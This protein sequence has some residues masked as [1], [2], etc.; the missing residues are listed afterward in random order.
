LNARVGAACFALICATG[1]AGQEPATVAVPRSLVVGEAISAAQRA[2]EIVGYTF[3][4]RAGSKYLIELAQRGLDFTVTVEGG[5]GARSYNSPLKRDETELVIVEA[6]QD[7]RFLVTVAAHELTDASGEHEIRLLL[8]DERIVPDQ[9]WVAAWRLMTDAAAANAAGERTGAEQARNWYSVAAAFWEQL[10]QTRRQAQALY[11][12]GMV[13]Y[14]GLENWGGAF[15]SAD[16]A[17]RLYRG[18]D[19]RLYANTLVLRAYAQIETASE[20]EAATQESVFQRALTTFDEA[21]RI[22]D[23]LGN[24]FDKAHVLNFIGITHW[25]R[26]NRALDDYA[27][28]RK[29]YNESADLFS[30]LGEWREEINCLQ[31]IVVLDNA[32]GR[33]LQAIASFERILDRLPPGRDPK[34][35]ATILANLGVAHLAFGNVDEALRLQSEAH[36]LSQAVHD[37][38]GEGY[39]LRNLGGIYFAFGDLSRAKLYLEQAQTLAENTNDFR[40]QATVQSSL[41][42]VAFAESDY[43]TALERH[44]RAADLTTSAEERA[45]RTLLMAKDLAAL[46]RHADAIAA[47][48][49]A[50]N[51]S[52]SE[53]TRADALLQT[54]VSYIALGE[55]SRAVS[56][57]DEAKTTYETLQLTAR[58]GDALHAYSVAARAEGDYAS[59][60]TYGRTALEKIESLRE[61]VAHP[62]LRAL[63]SA[64]R[65]RYYEDQIDLLMRRHEAGGAPESE[66]LLEALS[67]DERSRARLTLDLLGE[68][69][70]DLGREMDPEVAAKRRALYAALAEKR[71]QQE[72]PN[73]RE[74]ADQLA[75]EM[76]DIENELAL[77][78]TDHRR[79]H[80]VYS[81]IGSERTLDAKGIQAAIGGDA[82]LLQYTLGETRSY[83]WAITAESIRGVVLPGRAVIE[84]L[85]RAVRSD[86]G[87][88]PVSRASTRLAA[89]LSLLSGYLLKDV[90]DIVAAKSRVLVA[91][92]GA[93]QYIPF[94]VL[95]TA[96][97]ADGAKPPPFV[98]SAESRQIVTVA[99][100]SARSAGATASARS[101]P[102]VAVFAD[103][104]MEE[105]D[106]RFRANG[107]DTSSWAADS[108]LPTTRSFTGPSLSRLPYTGRE[109]RAIAD[110]LPKAVNLIA[111]GFDAN[112]DAVLAHDLRPYRYI[113]FATHGIVDSESPA[114]SALALS[115]FDE[116]RERRAGFLRLYDIYALELDAEV[117]VLSACDTGLGREIRGESLVGLTQGFLYAGARNVVASLWQVP[118]NA[119]S[120]LMTRFYRLMLSGDRSPAQ[121][122]AAA[123]RSMAEERPTAD[124]YYWGAF[125]IQE[126]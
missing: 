38:T 112:L 92:D 98:S 107:A 68:A 123:Q 31:N 119:T 56:A 90:A 67:V 48:T 26:A 41:G 24:D 95:P 54:A 42:N 58:L 84:G 25:M 32:E 88:S 34:L 69:A 114:L 118:D 105:T 94:G 7:E 19:E 44:Q 120:E 97:A 108:S 8:V 63:N 109:A 62:E 89:N 50:R 122:L 49:N 111:V 85:A 37:R 52:R 3:D 28:A 91:A 13:E 21:F 5:G 103:P 16:K 2:G 57:L 15:D 116:Q 65:R 22:H 72:R 87:R 53:V 61:R 121:A 23:A 1:V 106:A 43:A 82:V 9:R 117:V 80:P 64:A 47:A 66:Y 93:L 86:L 124:P 4:A 115:Q 14:H 60:L 51:E 11:S 125:V 30:R 45:R 73:S 110:L 102:S 46:G 126:R 40:T 29:N 81:R 101:T 113:H 59:A 99:S 77:L 104:V 75:V 17:S 6:A 18:L 39:S 79:A 70:V 36:A 83:A 100:I 27:V 20:F 10:G 12:V 96:L 33:S 76:R 71:Q 35:R 55:T 78:E 74:A